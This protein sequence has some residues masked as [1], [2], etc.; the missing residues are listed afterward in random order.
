MATYYLRRHQQS[1]QS[2]QTFYQYATIAILLLTLIA[3]GNMQQQ[4]QLMQQAPSLQQQQ[5]QQQQLPQQKQHA[6][7]AKQQQQQQ[8]AQQ[9]HQQHSN[10]IMGEAGVTNSQLS[11]PP[12][13]TH[14]GGANLQPG[15]AGGMLAGT[16]SQ[17]PRYDAPDDCHFLPAAGPE[18][19]EIALTCN[20]RTVNSEFDTTNFSVIPAEHTVALHVLCNDEIMAKSSLEARSFAHLVRLQ[21]LSIQYCKL[22]KFNR[23]VLEGLKQLR[24]LTVRT[25]NILWPTINFDI[26]ADAFAVVKNLERLDL[27][28]NNIWSLPDNIFCTLSGL[29]SLN[30]SENRLQDVNELGFRERSREQM[31]GVGGSEQSTAATPEV[32]TKPQQSTIGNNSSCNFDLEILDVSYNHFVLLPANGFGTLRRLRVLQVNNNEISMIADKA[33]SGL[34]NLQVLNL[35]SNKIVALPSEL[36]TEQA[37]SIQEVYLQNN[38]ISVLSPKLFSNLD[39]LQ[40]LDLSYNQITSTWIDRNTFVGL[41]RLVLLNLAHNKLTKLEPEIFTDLYTL[42]IL[43]L[44]HNQL[45]NIA[46]DTFAPMN[47]LHTLLLSHNRLKYLDAYALNG[48]Y[49]LSLLSLDNN[50][51]IGVHPEAF[52]NCSSLQDLNLNGNQLKTVPLALRNMR[53][54]RTVDLGENM[55]T[56]LEDNAFKGLGNL[57]GLR[58]IGN[59]LEN[60]TMN[61]F[62]D[63]PSLQIL[64]LAR[65]RI[66]VVEPGAFEMTSS[67]QAIRLDG[68]DLGEINGLFSNMP[69]LLWLNISDNRLE[70]FDYAHVPHTLQWLDLHKNR[71]GELSNRFSLD[72]QIRLQTLDAS[73]NQIQRI[74]PS[75]IPNSIE[76]LFLNDNLIHMVDP[77][78]FMHKSN[79]TRVDL[80][81]N[82]ITTLDI[83]SLRILPVHELRSL[84]EFYIG[85]NP[86]TCDCN[87]DWLQKINHIKSRQYPRIMDLETIYC[88]LLNNRERAYIP[89]I[90]AE[91]KH[92]LCTYKTH[93]FAVCHCCEF[94]ACDCEMTCP[95]NCTCF[96]DQTW[97]T[98]IVECSGAGYSQMPRKVPMD[99]TELYIDGNNFV[100]L[101][102]HTFLGRKNLAVLFVNNSN[103]QFLHN[104]TFSGLRRLLVLH[105]EDNH[106][107]EVHGDE[108]SNLENLRELYLQNN[109]ISSVGNGSFE[110]LRKLEVLRLDGNRLVHFEVW[111]LALNPY[112]VE[113]GLADNQWSC[114]CSY[115]MRFRTYLAQTAEKIVDAA[116]V[117]CV[118]NNA[119]SVLREKNGTKCTLRGDEITTY[120]HASEIQHLLPLLLVA[121][122]AFVGFFVLILGVFCYRHELKLWAHSNCL[123]NM[124]YT[125]RNAHGFV[126]TL[127]KDRLCDAYFAYSLQDEHFV[128][129]ILAQTLEH[130]IGYRLC[131]HYRDVNINAYVTDAIIEAAESAKQFVLVLSKNFLYNE[132]TRFE[133]KSALHEMVK[134][135]KRLVFILYGDL[136]QRDIDMDMRHYLRT[137]TCLEW[138]DK[139]FWQKLRIALPHIRKRPMTANCLAGRSAVNIY[140]SAHEYQP[141]GANAV[142]GGGLPNGHL[143]GGASVDKAHY[144]DC[145]NY[146]TINDC[147]VGARGYAPIPTA[148]GACKFNTL[149]ELSHK[150][151]KNDL[152]NNIGG[153]AGCIGLGGGA[154]TLDHHH[155]LRPHQQHEYAVPAYLGGLSNGHVGGG[156]APTYD[157]VD[158]AK[159]Q[160]LSASN[161]CDSCN[162]GTQKRVTK[163]GLHPSFSSNFTAPP[164][165]SI[166]G[167]CFNSYNCKKPCNCGARKHPAAASDDGISCRCGNAGSAAKETLAAATTTTTTPATANAHANNSNS[168]NSSNNSH[169]SSATNSS[170]NSTSSAGSG[171]R[172]PTEQ[173][174]HYESNSSLNESAA[175]NGPLWA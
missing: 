79:L 108:F 10:A 99:T 129:Q 87:I 132:W 39:Q 143:S 165:G 140:A 65:N 64:N 25:N 133:Y 12:T 154:K 95:T 137:S 124:C 22:A 61:A 164:N 172:Q 101:A 156:N 38:S 45:E 52:R 1:Q 173:L 63:L 111:Q 26:E 17:D 174:A 56:V 76:L 118:Y 100:E 46:A 167:T 62:K 121:T 34:K 139:K 109:R 169:S 30:M 112:L 161:N 120:A 153:G 175:L 159:Q 102:G 106:I 19:P 7:T 144:N 131:L 92:F 23:H 104:T 41:I 160:K 77:D 93:C 138:D 80:Y 86:F 163:G 18:H 8:Q 98:N 119:T 96:H 88:K 149:N 166:G 42:Q 81:A 49:V 134:R 152:L 150:L 24:N 155:H 171:N 4:Q 157:S 57:Y 21:E 135:R 148:A 69:S 146:A 3:G 29:S 37:G 74:S 16:A 51:L 28:S 91:P 78:T 60:I 59:Y 31:A 151:H 89:L 72:T 44:R 70:H 126:E 35:S 71:L 123:L 85:G 127:D 170:N 83:K 6:A 73:F 94:D 68:N 15:I 142:G 90:D 162:G 66:A 117:S 55:I 14:Y 58:L 13:A 53:L 40:A 141:A 50:A 110:A 122:C 103:V 114:E 168:S 145:N 147:G 84:P 116:R 33:L 97:S 130:D 128:N 48:L 11:K 82:Q 105:L 115:L 125:G 27:S 43:N 107:A 54:L 36:F 136:P 75:S 2:K 67:I 9:A 5:Q 47:N 20:L 113:I 158:Y 32:S